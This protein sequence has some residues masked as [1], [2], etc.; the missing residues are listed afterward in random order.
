MM[1]DYV[2]FEALLEEM[3]EKLMELSARDSRKQAR[4]RAN[5]V[6]LHANVTRK[7]RDEA[8]TSST[9]KVITW[10]FLFSKFWIPKS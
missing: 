3:T 7:Y 9:S 1:T 8:G 2:A 5:Q 4:L 6:R 10:N